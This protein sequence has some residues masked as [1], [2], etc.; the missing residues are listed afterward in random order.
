MSDIATG[1]DADFSELRLIERYNADLANSLGNLLNRTLNMA[2]KY[3]QGVIENVVPSTGEVCLY[4]AKPNSEFV[5]AQLRAYQSSFGSNYETDAALTDAL[6]IAGCGNQ[7]VDRE[8]PWKLAKDP[9][10]SER[11]GAVLYTLAES[12]RIIAILIAPVLPKA[13]AGIFAQ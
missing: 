9:V 4:E 12:L 10:Q 5:A 11:L 1:H 2:Q 13:A 3:R 7:M 6:G 8:A